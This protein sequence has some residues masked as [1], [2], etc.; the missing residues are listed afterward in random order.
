ML[1]AAALSFVKAADARGVFGANGQLAVVGLDLSTGQLRT[2]NNSWPAGSGTR[3]LPG[4][5][6]LWDAEYALDAEYV[7]VAWHDDPAVYGFYSQGDHVRTL[8]GP[9]DIGDLAR[10]KRDGSSSPEYLGKGPDG[11]FLVV[12]GYAYW[13]SRYEGVKRRRLVP[14]APNELVWAGPDVAYFW[15]IGIAAG[16]F[17][18]S[19][20]ENAGPPRTF[21]VESVP[22]APGDGG[23]EPP[24]VH[25]A[26]LPTPFVDAVVDGAC[27]YSASRTGVTRANLNEGKVQALV[28]GHPVAGDATILESRFLAM[29]GRFLYWA[30]YGGDRVVRWKR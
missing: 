12:D 7:Y 23:V 18:F 4:V 26:S 24:R 27:A 22:I 20:I 19:A 11:R 14:D 15:P 5:V 9:H 16:R 21:A 30:D 17:Y 25:A 29:D 10:V 6:R 1:D 28:E 13:G 2:L 8:K 3:N